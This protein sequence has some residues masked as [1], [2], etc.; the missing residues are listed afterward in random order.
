[1][2][3]ESLNSKDSKG[4]TMSKENKDSKVGKEGKK[5]MVKFIMMKV[6]MLIVLASPVTKLI[7]Y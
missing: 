7:C 6:A 3:K 1:V 4:S 5:S 2:S